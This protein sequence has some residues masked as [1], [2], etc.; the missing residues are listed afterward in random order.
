MRS[1]SSH[2]VAPPRD[3]PTYQIDIQSQSDIAS[4]RMLNPLILPAQRI[5]GVDYVEVDDGDSTDAV[6]AEPPSFGDHI[7]ASVG[8][9][10]ILGAATLTVLS[11]AQSVRTFRASRLP[12][13]V[14]RTSMINFLTSKAKRG[15]LTGA[16]MTIIM[17]SVN[18]VVSSLRNR[19]DFISESLSM[20]ASAGLY[21]MI[22]TQSPRAALGMCGVVSS[23]AL[24]GHTVIM[25]WEMGV[26]DERKERIYQSVEKYTGPLLWRVDRTN[27]SH[28]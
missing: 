3:L 23:Y 18:S 9:G 16:A 8:S 14:R 11:F 28:D 27:S 10:F 2:P 22:R 6:G 12:N 21:Q 7:T 26:S 17:V 5:K 1:P 24:F 15:A 20:G 13:K 25:V 4:A 19:E